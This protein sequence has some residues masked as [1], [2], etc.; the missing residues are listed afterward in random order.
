MLMT[1]MCQQADMV[2]KRILVSGTGR[3]K[4]ELVSGR[5]KVKSGKLSLRLA[6]R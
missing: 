1:Q 2:K 5:G 6:N 4:A 3:V